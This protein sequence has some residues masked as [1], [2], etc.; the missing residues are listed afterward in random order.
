[1]WQL[2]GSE[3]PVPK[4][5]YEASSDYTLAKAKPVYLRKAKPVPVTPNTRRNLLQQ[6]QRTIKE[7]G[8]EGELWL[9]PKRAAFRSSS[10]VSVRP[11]LKAKQK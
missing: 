5:P 1:M 7:E 9:T 3:P 2:D 4:S 6:Q 10:H 11:G 8:G